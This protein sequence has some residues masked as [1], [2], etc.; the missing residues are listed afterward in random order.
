MNPLISLIIPAYNIEPWLPRCLD[1][2]LA[3]TYTN[4]EIL[5]VNDGS[6]DGTGA[7]IDAYAARDSRVKAIHKENGGVTSARLRGIAE[8]TGEWIGFVDGDDYVEPE[9]FARLLE[10]ALTHQADISHCGYQMVYP[11]GHTDYYYNSGRLV[12][13]DHDQGLIDLISGSFIEP[14]LVTKLYRRNLMSGLSDWLDTD[15]RNLEDLL[16]NYYLFHQ[17][18]CAVYEGVCPYHY[19]LRK[20]S[21][22]TAKLNIH[23]LR[24]P[25]RVI[26]RIYEEAPAAA[27]PAAL[28]R[29]ARCLIT[30]ATMSVGDQKELILPY[31]RETRRE[32]RQRLRE[33]LRCGEC[34]VK[35][36]IM[37]LWAALWPWSYGFVHRVYSRVTG[38][39]KKYSV[40]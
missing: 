38:L 29:L 4:L 21:A 12:Q 37:A 23:K 33:I 39:D 2:L 36:K 11:D 15:V 19:I 1:S 24:D 9:M 17:A 32:L 20:G 25:L 34:G 18:E 5:V 30:G 31:R 26:R 22:S 7:V 10:N 40:E 6:R 27:K 16:M 28:C 35:L 3:Q 8:A 14:G 13:Q